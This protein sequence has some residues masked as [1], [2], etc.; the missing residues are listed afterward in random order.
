MVSVSDG[1][2]LLTM[3]EVL[4]LTGLGRKT[5]YTYMRGGTFPLPLKCGPKNIRFRASQIDEWIDG[6]P[7]ATGDLG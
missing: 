6:L 1:E 2:K 4:K 5:I 7:A 3:A